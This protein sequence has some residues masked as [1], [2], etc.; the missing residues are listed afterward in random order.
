MKKSTKKNEVYRQV[1]DF[2]HQG[3]G[4]TRQTLVGST[5]FPINTICTSVAALIKEGWLVERGDVNHNGRK[6][7]LL[8][9]TPYATVYGK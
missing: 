8:Y 7:S 1:R 6:R 2:N 9:T 3:I 5:D 4:V